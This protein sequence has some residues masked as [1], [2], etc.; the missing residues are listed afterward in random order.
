M[1]TDE[2]YSN[3]NNDIKSFSS[4]YE[5]RIDLITY[6]KNER[7]SINLLVNGTEMNKFIL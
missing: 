1:I 6:L 3:W 4:L 2:V 5:S 7:E